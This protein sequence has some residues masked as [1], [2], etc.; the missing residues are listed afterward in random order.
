MGL[1]D[2]FRATVAQPSPARLPVGKFAAMPQ[3]GFMRVVGESQYQPVLTQLAGRCVPG[4]EGRPSFP[5]ALVPEPDNPYDAHAIA[6]VS[7]LGHVGYLPRDDA[8]RYGLTMSFLRRGGYD[9]G[10][11]SALLNGGSRDRPSYGVTLCVGYPRDCETHFGIVAADGKPTAGQVRGRHYTDYVS[12][13]RALRRNGNDVAAEQL[14][15]EL[16]QATETESQALGCG[17][18]PWYYEQLAIIYRK[19]NDQDAEIAILERYAA[20]PHAPG[21]GSAKLT[22]RLEKARRR[23]PRR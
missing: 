14:L 18:A 6:V 11:C 21:A 15:L 12:D 13:V 1:L 7:E 16:V 23:D 2:R 4:A 8:P 3:D 19:R 17:V 20:K 10:S 9:G 22:E 5:V